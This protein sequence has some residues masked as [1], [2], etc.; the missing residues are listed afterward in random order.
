MLPIERK[1]LGAL[2]KRALARPFGC[3]P[4][5]EREED[6]LGLDSPAYL[7]ANKGVEIALDAKLET[8]RDFLA[9]HLKPQRKLVNAVLFTNGA[10]VESAF[11]EPPPEGS[12]PRVLASA[13][14]PASPAASDAA[15]PQ[16]QP[17]RGTTVA[18]PVRGCPAPDF[19]DA[20]LRAAQV[21]RH[22]LTAQQLDDYQR[23]NR[24]VAVGATTGHRYMLTSRHRQR[25]L[26]RFGG[27]SLYDLDE[28]QPYCVHDWEVPA[29]EE[30]LGL[31]VFLALPGREA[32]LRE[33][34]E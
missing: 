21:L 26:D 5:V 22:F 14:A 33:I 8:V 2:R 4:W 15:K 18:A 16:E 20:E 29:A 32:Y 17:Q 24:F 31:L 11:T 30:L 13:P 3:S 23:Y 1:A 19:S 10:I 28:G 6:F 9:R 34:V 25:E 12:E 7:E 27:R